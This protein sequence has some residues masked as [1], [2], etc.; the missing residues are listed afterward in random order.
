MQ[1]AKKYLSPHIET[2]YQEIHRAAGLLAFSEDTDA[3]PY[4]VSF[5]QFQ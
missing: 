3:E 2:Q 4:K 1:H 5:G